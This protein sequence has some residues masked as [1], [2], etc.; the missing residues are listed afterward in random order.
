MHGKL[1]HTRIILVLQMYYYMMH[2]Y[3]IKQWLLSFQELNRSLIC[4]FEGTY[5]FNAGFV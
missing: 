5:Y 2:Y 1:R 4:G 3:I